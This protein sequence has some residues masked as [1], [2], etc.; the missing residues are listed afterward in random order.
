MLCEIEIAR[1][2]HIDLN[3]LGPRCY[4]ISVELGSSFDHVHDPFVHV[5]SKQVSCTR[6]E[7][8]LVFG[9]RCHAGGT[10]QG[11]TKVKPNE[12]EVDVA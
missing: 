5:H 9:R 8:R 4:F 10:T 6:D 1:P 7:G 12:V 11:C 3:L 2:T